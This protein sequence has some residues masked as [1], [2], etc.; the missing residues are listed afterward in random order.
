MHE[1]HRASV[2]V[3]QSQLHGDGLFSDQD[4]TTGTLLLVVQQRNV[5]QPVW[6]INH[7]CAP[8][9]EVDRVYVLAARDIQAGEE[10]TI[11]YQ[12]IKFDSEVVGVAELAA[13]S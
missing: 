6:H 11:N 7:S 10:L 12:Q 4:V 8:N 13:G 2:S 9:C 3:K 5:E 1:H